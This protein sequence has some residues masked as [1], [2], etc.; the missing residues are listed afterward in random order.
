LLLITC[1]HVAGMPLLLE[2]DALTVSMVVDAIRS[3][4]LG[5]LLMCLVLVIVAAWGPRV[6]GRRGS[7]EA[8]R[9]RWQYIL[10]ALGW[11]ATASCFV[12]LSFWLGAGLPS[13]TTTAIGIWSGLYGLVLIGRAA[14][15]G[16]VQSRQA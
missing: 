8:P 4:L 15:W 3:G 16:G 6:N 12:L 13:R 11:L 5:G 9:P 7:A 1:M 2:S 14:S 10:G